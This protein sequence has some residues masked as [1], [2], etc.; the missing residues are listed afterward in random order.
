MKGTI[1][2]RGDSYRIKVPLGKNQLTGKYDAYYETFRGSKPNAQKRLRQLLTDLDKGMFVKPCKGTITE[3]L[4]S[5]LT[6]YCLNLS[7]RT[8]ELYSYMCEKHII[9]SIG[10]IPLA[11]LKPPHV[12]HLYAEKLSSGL[13][14]RTVQIIH[15][16][17]HKALKTAVKAGLVVRNV[18][19]AVDTPRVQRHEIHTMDETDIHLFLDT[20]RSTEYF[21]FFY[22]LL[23]TGCRRSELLAVRWQ[24]V[25]L[26]LRQLSI[27]R[28][29]QYLRGAKIPI[30]FKEP[31]TQNSRRSIVLSRSTVE[32]LKEHRVVQE[33]RRES[34]HLPPV[35][36]SDLIFSH[37]NG[38][39][40]LP[41]SVTQAWERLARR[42]GLA[43]VR[44][45]DARHSHASLML[46]QGIHLKV[47]SER[48][49]HSGI[50]ITADTYSHITPGLQQAAAD[51][52]D[53]L[54][55]PKT[56]PQELL[57]QRSI[58]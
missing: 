37:Y 4:R 24:D 44:L 51:M 50:Q 36:P 40:L 19:E 53:D 5:W 7:P 14:P 45:H 58:E 42:S 31:K 54:L 52:F 48:L 3:Y 33:K 38:T 18:T 8:R 55:L 17:L 27:T 16:T 32:V 11:E 49:G 43:G 30:T 10:N 29:M 21:T 34:L 2:E 47:V 20:A 46:K 39:P 41:Q 35:S 25:D 12:Q 22:T 26:L 1:I 13:S 56:I 57:G 15:V 6:D 23:F 28:S 9:P